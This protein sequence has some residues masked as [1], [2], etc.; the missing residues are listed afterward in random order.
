MQAA[1]KKELTM[2]YT[3]FGEL[4]RI[5]RIKHHEVL[6]DVKSFLGV[7]SAFISSVE[8]GKKPI[9]S[10]WFEKL[11][12]HY[13]LSKKEQDELA[14]AIDVSKKAL[15]IDISTASATQKSVAI[16]FQRSFDGLDE[17]TANEIMEILERN[18]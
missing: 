15:K 3:E 16:Q 2:G 11:S 18:K 4:F 6:A 17:K 8:C 12:N 13:N 5:L 1:T 7:S 10:D 9:P 14:Y